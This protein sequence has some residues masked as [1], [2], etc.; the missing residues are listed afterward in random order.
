[1]QAGATTRV[2]RIAFAALAALVFVYVAA[3]AVLVPVIHDEA[4]TFFVYVETGNFLPFRAHWDAGNHLLCTA[5]AWLGWSAFGFSAWALRLPSVL[6][7]IL[8]TAYAWKWGTRLHGPMV[9]WGLWAA[10]LGM[11]FL[12]D[13]FSLFRGYGLAM[14]FWSMA[15]YEGCS[16]LEKRSTKR[17]LLVLLA[18]A[19]AAFSSLSLL[20]LW[21]A[22]LAVTLFVALR[23]P[24]Q[25]GM[26]A[27]WLLLGA[28]PFTFAA[29]YAY[30]LGL[31][32]ALYYGTDTGMF[33]GTVPSLLKAMF[34]G[35]NMLAV[36]VVVLITVAGIVVAWRAFRERDRS[37]GAWALIGTAGLVWADVLG[38]ELLF[39]WNGTL[40]PEDR[41]ALQWVLLFV[42]LFAFALDRLAKTAPRLK[43]LALGLLLLPL[44]TLSTANLRTTSFWPEQAIPSSIFRAAEREQQVSPRLLTI[45]AY[46][47]MPACWG[48]G[49]RQRGLALNAVDVS[50]FPNGGEALLLID[51]HR[52]SVPSDYRAVELAPG[53]HIALY[54]RETPVNT[55][56]LL[57]TTFTGE[58]SDAEYKELWHPAIGTVR[59]G[60][61]LVELEMALRPDREPM[62]GDF[63][64]E[65]NAGGTV[66]HTD[67]V[68]FQFMRDPPRSDSIR[69]V[70]HIPHVPMDAERVV[71][72]LWNP[73]LQ[74]YACSGRMRIYLVRDGA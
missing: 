21:A 31:R 56:L 4:M 52:D 45:G 36:A 64:L 14:A 32:G 69:T 5:L 40:F 46:H 12:L 6:A 58:R 29:A 62:T 54:A 49:L 65:T 68:L 22:V 61:F 48:F 51:P 57:D 17:L 71:V 41:T 3:R 60:T 15:L 39:A 43:W 7:F 27:G 28:F 18:S 42:L 9:R 10:L 23:K 8:Y 19:C 2:E 50:A 20:T 74:W 63:V 1:M 25:R 16:L 24:V 73:S 66:Q 34:G 59:G 44:R 11:P 53:G 26:L 47:Q 30:Q 33:R 37:F 55:T 35:S 67:H 70:R 72:Y 13:L 38:R